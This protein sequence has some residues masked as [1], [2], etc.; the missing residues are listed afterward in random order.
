MPMYFVELRRTAPKSNPEYTIVSVEAEH[1]SVV[2][3][4]LTT[5]MVSR[6]WKP[7]WTSREEPE[8]WGLPNAIKVHGRASKP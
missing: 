6:E 3:A 5:L 4:T 8:N 2:L 7:V 1:H